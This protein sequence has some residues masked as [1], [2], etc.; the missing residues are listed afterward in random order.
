MM[1]VPV[2]LSFTFPPS[3]SQQTS[4]FSRYSFFFSLLCFPFCFCGVFVVVV[5]FSSFCLM[6]FFGAGASYQN[7]A[8]EF[9][10]C[11]FLPYIPP[12]SIIPFRF[13][14]PLTE[15]LTEALPE[16][17]TLHNLRVPKGTV[18]LS[19]FC[20]F[21][22]GTHREERWESHIETKNFKPFY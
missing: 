10:L 7:S 19:G 14:I 3:S 20:Y 12:L 8:V 22:T 5:F 16:S 15:S 18:P 13:L 17:P 2:S 9:P 6:V 21:L 1:S 4:L 11:Q